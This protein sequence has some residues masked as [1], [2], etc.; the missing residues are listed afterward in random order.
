MVCTM[1]TIM[2]FPPLS[3]DPLN[4]RVAPLMGG[5]SSVG[6]GIA[7][8]RPE[9]KVLVLDGDGS[10]AM[11]LGTLLT[12]SEAAPQNLFHFVF[13]NGVLY[14]G[15]GRLPIA[16]GARADFLGLALSAGYPTAHS[17]ETAAALEAGL[18]GVLAG[19]GPALIR[20]AI[21]LPPTPRWSAEHPQAEL[22]DWWF[23]QMGEDARTA[24]AALAKS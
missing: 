12:I 2:S 24:K 11:Q 4:I 8:A 15:G 18:P 9:R 17:F 3:P 1:S 19:P 7:L 13:H 14:E 10:L 21:D 16:G 23:T 6:L 5:S 20:L 22:P